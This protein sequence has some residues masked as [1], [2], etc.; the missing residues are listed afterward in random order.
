MAEDKSSE[1]VGL[2]KQVCDIMKD[3]D[4]ASV[5]LREGDVTL[6]VTAQPNGVPMPSALGGQPGPNVL[7]QTVGVPSPSAPL[8]E[9]SQ[10]SG[11]LIKSPMVGIFYRAADIDKPPFVEIGDT[12]AQDDDLCLIEAMK[13]FNPVL[14]PF[15]CEIVE[16]L[17]ENETAVEY[18]QPLFRIKRI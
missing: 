10:E 4:L 6:R 13:I 15:P 2:L 12:V 9:S 8:P 17:V 7:P 3:Y 14:A 5:Y 1:S 16:I 11:E 18:D